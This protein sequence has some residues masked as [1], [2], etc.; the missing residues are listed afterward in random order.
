MSKDYNQMLDDLLWKEDFKVVR[1]KRLI[2]KGADPNFPI[3]EDGKTIL[4]GT[5]WKD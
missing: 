2:K 3:E 5:T 4:G 1:A